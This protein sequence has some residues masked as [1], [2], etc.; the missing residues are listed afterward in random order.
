MHRLIINTFNN[1]RILI[2]KKKNLKFTKNKK[3]EKV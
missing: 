3:T 2:I 1:S